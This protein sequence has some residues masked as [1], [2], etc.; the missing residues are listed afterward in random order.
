MTSLAPVMAGR[1][2]GSGAQRVPQRSEAVAERFELGCGY[3]VTIGSIAAALDRVEEIG[4][5]STQARVASPV[6]TAHQPR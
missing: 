5:A 2:R 3:R 1:A 4:Q 6:T